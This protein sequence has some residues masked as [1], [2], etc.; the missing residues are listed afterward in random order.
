MPACYRASSQ[1][2]VRA[3]ALAD[4]RARADAALT[5]SVWVLLTAFGLLLLIGP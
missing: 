3:A 4:D 1:H 2:V 5:A